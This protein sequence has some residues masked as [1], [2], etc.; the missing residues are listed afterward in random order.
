MT[1]LESLLS[2]NI[3]PVPVNVIERIC[4]DRTLT[5][6]ST[7]TKELGASQAFR[8]AYADILKWL[9]DAPSIVE[10]EVGINN[11]ISI[12]KDMLDEANGIYAEYDDPKFSGKIIGFI[13]EN[14]NG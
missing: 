5:S 3:Y 12:Q 9:H 2:V 8:L 6:S 11:A 1:V 4:V 10:Q 14:W 13:G 7:Y